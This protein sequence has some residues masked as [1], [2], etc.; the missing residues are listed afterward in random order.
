MVGKLN[1]AI[2]GRSMTRKRT[3]YLEWRRLNCSRQTRAGG[4]P[5][6]SRPP[7][8]NNGREVVIGRL[9]VISQ[10]LGRSRGVLLKDRVIAL[11]SGSSLRALANDWFTKAPQMARPPSSQ[12]VAQPT[13][14][15]G[16]SL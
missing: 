14:V 12:R 3:Q 8:S 1:G 13:T 7:P 4:A 11:A 10:S 15:G 2:V 6:T 5:R 16:V 9:Q